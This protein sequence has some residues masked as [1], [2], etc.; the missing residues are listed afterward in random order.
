MKTFEIG[1]R[2]MMRSICDYDCIWVY[3]VT[4]RTKSTVTLSDENGKV[5]RCRISKWSEQFGCEMVMPLGSYSMAPT[6]SADKV[7]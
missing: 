6:L 1:K 2:Y 3:S 7:A 4:A 5:T